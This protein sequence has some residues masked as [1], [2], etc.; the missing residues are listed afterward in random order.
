MSRRREPKI[1]RLFRF[2]RAWSEKLE[3]RRY[4]ALENLP[5]IAPPEKV[6]GDAEIAYYPN[7]DSR[8]LRATKLTELE[9][10]SAAND[11]VLKWA[12]LVIFAIVSLGVAYVSHMKELLEAFFGYRGD[13][14]TLGNYWLHVLII[15]MTYLFYFLRLENHLSKLDQKWAQS[16]DAFFG[17][18]ARRQMEAIRDCMRE[19]KRFVKWRRFMRLALLILTPVV[20]I[21]VVAIIGTWLGVWSS[22]VGPGGIRISGFSFGELALLKFGEWQLGEQLFFYELVAWQ[23]IWLFFYWTTYVYF[24]L[25]R[26]PTLHMCALVNLLDRA[27]VR[28]ADIEHRAS[29]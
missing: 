9:A 27:R 11:Y 18:G 26:D 5:G 28:P 15:G 8:A 21:E 2:F 10:K 29:I 24:T 13:A 20:V 1:P 22:P 4:H 25:F 16:I 17:F 19:F 23:V 7:A 6:S 14:F 3:A 12:G